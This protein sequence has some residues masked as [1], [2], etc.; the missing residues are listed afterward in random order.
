MFPKKKK[1]KPEKQNKKRFIPI[2][3]NED[4]T[5]KKNYSMVRETIIVHHYSKVVLTNTRN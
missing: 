4:I 3:K 1:K 2:D 5:N